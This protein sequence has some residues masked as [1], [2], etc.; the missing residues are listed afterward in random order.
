MTG[1]ELEPN[2]NGSFPVRFRF[3]SISV[4]FRFRF[5][6]GHVTLRFARVNAALSEFDLKKSVTRAEPFFGS[7]TGTVRFR[8]RA[9]IRG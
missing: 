7:G 1:T 3:G 8:F 4:P 6:S 9:P 2:R 5:G